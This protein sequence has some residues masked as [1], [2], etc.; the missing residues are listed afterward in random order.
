MTWKRS[1]GLWLLVVLLAAPAAMAQ[2]GSAPTATGET[3]LFTLLSPETL[4]QGDWSFSLYYNNWDRVFKFDTDAGMDIHQLSASLGWG[5]TDRFELAVQVPYLRL[6][7]DFPNNE[8]FGQLGGKAEDGLGNVHVGGKWW[9]TGERGQGGFALNAYVE[10]PTGD[11]KVLAGDTGFGGGLSWANRHWV[12]DAGFRV[13][14]DLTFG[15]QKYSVS[16]EVSAGIGNIVPITSRLDWITELAGTFPTASAD[17]QIYKENVDLTTG[18]R[19]WF[20]EKANWAFNFGLRTDLLQLDQTDVHCPLGGVLGVTYFPRWTPPPPPPP[21]AP[22]PEPPP[23]PPP[24][25][26]PKPAPPPPP[27]PAPKPKPEER[28]TVQFGGGSARLSNIAKAKLDDVALRMKQDPSAQALVI[29]YT[30][31]RG[32]DAANQKMSE[33]RAEAVKTYLVQRHGIDA[34]RIQTEGRGSA[35]PVASNDTAAGRA[36]NR[37]AVVIITFE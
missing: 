16:E 26:E 34:S 21:P 22:A 5:I 23:P 24:A 3:G 36:Q 31:S 25:P 12:F 29:G 20:G 15:N 37:R 35:E 9:L 18:G 11:D 6:D 14:G 33:R 7:G 19:L 1:S 13:P 8:M 17:K 30:D 4:P 28:V 10:A 32:S 2:P 27:P